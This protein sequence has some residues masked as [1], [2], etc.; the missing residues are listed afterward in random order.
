MINLANSQQQQPQQ[1]PSSG[2]T[3]PKSPITLHDLSKFYDTHPPRSFNEIDDDDDDEE[4]DFFE[5]YNG[6]SD[7]EAEIEEVTTQKILSVDY[8]P[9]TLS[10]LRNQIT[11]HFESFESYSSSVTLEIPTSIRTRQQPVTTL[12]MPTAK[13]SSKKL[14]EPSTP[15]PAKSKRVSFEEKSHRRSKSS[16]Q[17][18]IYYSFR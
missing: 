18:P 10:Q 2:P 11:N 9:K 16:E 12:R 8:S 5:D 1:V 4:E 3:S 14:W 17:D 15:Q 13:M 7:D 6:I